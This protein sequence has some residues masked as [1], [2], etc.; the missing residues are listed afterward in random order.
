MRTWWI[1]THQ[2]EFKHTYVCLGEESMF[3]NVLNPLLEFRVL[4]DLSITLV[5]VTK[6]SF[7]KPERKKNQ[8]KK[9]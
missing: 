6:H 1:I 5:V 9:H 7:H 8:M 3:K 4:A 2:L